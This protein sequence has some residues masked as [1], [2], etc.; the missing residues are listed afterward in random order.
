MTAFKSFP[1]PVL[2][3]GDD[4][5]GD[6]SFSMFY[7]LEPER[8][9]LDGTFHLEHETIEK[10]IDD[11]RA[12]F[13]AEVVCKAT[14]YRDVFEMGSSSFS[15]SISANNLRGSVSVS[16]YVCANE[17]IDE[18][19]PVGVHCDLLGGTSD[20]EPGEILAIGETAIFNAE[21]SFDPLRAPVSSFMRIQ[22]GTARTGPMIVD[23]GSEKII[24]QLAQEDHAAY[25]DLPRKR[26]AGI[27]HASIVLPVLTDALHTMA[28]DEGSYRDQQWYTR[29]EQICAERGLNTDEPFESAQKI[30]QFPLARSFRNVKEEMELD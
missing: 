1:N 16:S 26:I 7:T 30:L 25:M 3:N 4:I 17:K 18:Y 12:R 27:L 19:D 20:I 8:V 15:R 2:G 6:F 9:L 10:L 11:G 13:I 24:I 23:Y 28:T 5:A 22:K 29:I 14:F 21:K